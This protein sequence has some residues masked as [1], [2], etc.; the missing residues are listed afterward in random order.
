MDGSNIPTHFTGA[1]YMISQ[2]FSTESPIAYTYI[3]HI[4]YGQVPGLASR[5][6]RLD[7]YT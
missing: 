3:A 7:I 5:S 1:K 2:D 6:V 4:A